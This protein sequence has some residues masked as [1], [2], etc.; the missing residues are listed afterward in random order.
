MKV[1][2]IQD[3]TNLGKKGDI[4][5]VSDGYARNFLLPRKLAQTVTDSAI[6]N[7]E[8]KKDQEAKEV[9]DRLDSLK[10]LAG[11]LNKKEFVI[12]CKEKG[13][14]LF[15]S[16]SEKDIAKALNDMGIEIEESSVILEA[17]LKKTGEYSINLKLEKDIISRI[18]L[19][20]QGA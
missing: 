18:K 13:G 2:L 16:V 10:K 14:K 19:K 6:K 4:K 11:S 8:N 20:I 15:G 5:E 17:P 12:K 9:Q 3:I 7:M 1:I